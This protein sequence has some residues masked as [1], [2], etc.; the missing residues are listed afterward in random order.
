MHPAKRRSL[1]RR[2]R[3]RIERTLDHRVVRWMGLGDTQQVWYLRK[4]FTLL[5][6]DLVIDVGGNLGQYAS[7]LR[8]RVRY[9]GALITVEPIP[10]MAQALQRRFAKD[11]RWAL[12]SFALG[13]QPGRAILNVM[14]GH[15]LSSLLAPSNVA[16]DRLD[17]FNR[18]QERVDV[19]VSTLE[20]LLREHPLAQGALNIYLKLDV[21][22]YELQV[23]RGVQDALPRIA[24]LQAEASVIPLYAG[25]PSY[26]ELMREIDAM[27]F[28]LSFIPAHNYTQVPDMIDFDCHFVS[29][30]R[31]IALGY[32]CAPS[33]AVAVAATTAPI[34]SRS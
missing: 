23:L 24:A 33:T 18:V 16:T 30:G 28:Q 6:I 20:Q 22:G 7:L 14:Q 29:R 27:G 15:Q 1:A 34:T 9:H 4:L 21:Q 12:A 8:D 5:D 31:L 26:H 10:A 2:L 11:P 19:E 25:V 3:D 13:E 17:S 32:L